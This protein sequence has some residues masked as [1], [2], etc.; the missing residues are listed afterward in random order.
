M[1]GK[2]VFG[3][4]SDIACEDKLTQKAAT[5]QSARFEI[6]HKDACVIHFIFWGKC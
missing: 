4:M 1:G 5:I 2:W 3:V 6:D